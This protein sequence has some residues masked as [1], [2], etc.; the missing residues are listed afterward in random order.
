[1]RGSARPCWIGSRTVLTFWRQ[2][3]NRI[4][5]GDRLPKPRKEKN[6]QTRN[7]LWKCRP[8]ES[9]ESQNQASHPFHRPWTARK[10]SG[11]PTFPQL[12]RLVLRDQER[13]SKAGLTAEPKSV[14]AECGPKQTGEVG[15]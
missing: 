13:L 6:R 8:V 9:M 11:L 2:E 1:M 14:N 4:A 12:R 3:R 10:S 7:K 15:Q 5:S